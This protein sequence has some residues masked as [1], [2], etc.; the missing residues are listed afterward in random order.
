MGNCL[1]RSHPYLLTAN[2]IPLGN[3]AEWQKT[4]QDLKQSCSLLK[5]EK[6]LARAEGNT[7]ATNTAH[8]LE[9]SGQLSFPCNRSNC[10]ADLA[11]CGVQRG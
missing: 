9:S 6:H 10:K 4:Q 8:A 11:C 2:F 7:N 5:L 3:L 1:I